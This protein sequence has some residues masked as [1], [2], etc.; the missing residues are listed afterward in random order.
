MNPDKEAAH[1]SR[2]TSPLPLKAIIGVLHLNPLPGSPGYPGAGGLEAAKEAVLADAGALEQGGVDALLLENYGDTPF[3]P[4][5]VEPH[6]VALMSVIL[7]E[8]STRSSLP[9]GVNVVRNDAYAA[10]GIALAT[11]ASFMRVNVL[12]GA[13]TTDQGIIHGEAHKV[14]RYRKSLNSSTAILADVHVKH[15]R[16]LAAGESIEEAARDAFYRGHADGLIVTGPATGTAIDL[17]D[18]DKVKSAV[19][20]AP[21]FAGSGVC[22]KNVKEILA[23]ADGVIVGTSLEREG[24]TGAPVDISRVEKLVRAARD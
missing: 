24:K 12:T 9:L 7:K 10:L 21:V 8:I 16:P 18:I 2:G 17:N 23:L 4:G 15:G 5:R 13:C 19:I 20:E 6:T 22:E 1:P 11:E 14:L 3:L